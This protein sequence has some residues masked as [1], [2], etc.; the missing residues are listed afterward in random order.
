[1]KVTFC[2]SFQDV[3]ITFQRAALLVVASTT[4]VFVYGSRSEET[5]RLPLDQVLQ[6]DCHRNIPSGQSLSEQIDKSVKTYF[7]RVVNNPIKAVKKKN[8]ENI[9]TRW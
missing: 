9:I 5:W 4:M 3:L 2:I 1:M 6:S 7:R 8:Y